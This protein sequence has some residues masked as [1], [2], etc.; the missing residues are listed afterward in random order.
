MKLETDQKYAEKQL[1]DYKRKKDIAVKY[2][3]FFVLSKIQPNNNNEFYNKETKFPTITNL[4][5]LVNS[6]ERSDEEHISRNATGWI[7]SERVQINNGEDILINGNEYTVEAATL[8]NV[9]T[10][11]MILRDKSTNQLAIVDTRKLENIDEMYDILKNRKIELKNKTA[12]KQ[13]NR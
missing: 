7:Y 9:M 4:T 11:E 13:K 8:R 6:D 10:R 2:C 5:D 1:S 3:D 12:I